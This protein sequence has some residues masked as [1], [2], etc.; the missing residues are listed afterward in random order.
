MI[1]DV[2][3]A[4]PLRKKATSIERRM[5]VMLENADLTTTFANFKELS[6]LSPF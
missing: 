4:I 3:S 5:S 2:Y 6:K 1:Q